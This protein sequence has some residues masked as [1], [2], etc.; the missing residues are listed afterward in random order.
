MSFL[1]NQSVFFFFK[2][3]FFN[4]LDKLHNLKTQKEK[5]EK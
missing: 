2:S 1:L 5:I 4:D 3:N